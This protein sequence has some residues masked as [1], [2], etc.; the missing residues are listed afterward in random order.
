MLIVGDIA[1]DSRED[2]CVVCLHLLI[3][4]YVVL[5]NSQR[6]YT[7]LRVYRLKDNRCALRT[8]VL[9]YRRQD[10][11]VSYPMVNKYRGDCND[12]ARAVG[13]AL[14][15]LIIGLLSRK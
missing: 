9:W 5:S 6:R 11:N 8:V 13:T 7:I 14:I 4:L 2:F 15:G 10:I 12:V 1:A 3:S